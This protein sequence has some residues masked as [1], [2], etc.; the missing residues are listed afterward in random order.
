MSSRYQN[1][2]VSHR[3]SYKYLEDSEK[4]SWEIKLQVSVQMAFK[5]MILR[6]LRCQIYKENKSEPELNSVRWTGQL[7][8]I[9]NK[10]TDL[11]NLKNLLKGQQLGRCQDFKLVL[12]LAISFLFLIMQCLFYKPFCNRKSLISTNGF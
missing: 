10:K 12:W 1:G 5:S 2:D 8:H 4:Y 9:T 11:E 3:I 7:L 6:S